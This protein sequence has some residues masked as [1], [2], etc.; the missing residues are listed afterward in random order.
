MFYDDR[1]RYGA[2]VSARLAALALS[3][4]AFAF[5]LAPAA[6]AQ[7]AQPPPPEEETV[8]EGDTIVV[9]GSILRGNANSINPIGILSADDM[10]A[11]GQT[12]IA[13]ALQTLSGNAG[14][15]LPNSFTA[16]GA[17]AG[18]ASTVSLRGLLSS[19]TLTLVD[20]MRLSY[21]PLSDDGTRNFVDLNTIPQDV[22]ARVETLKDGASS[23]YGAD[24]IAGVIN[25]ITRREYQ[26]ASIDSSIAFRG[27]GDG[28]EQFNLSG[29][30]GHGDLGTDGYNFYISAEY[31]RQDIYWARDADFF[32]TTTSDLTSICGLTVNALDPADTE[33]CIA[34]GVFWGLEHDGTF[35]APAARGFGSANAMIRAWDGTQYVGDFSL[36][37]TSCNEHTTPGVIPGG[38]GVGFAADTNVCSLDPQ[39][40]F[41]VV[42]PEDTRASLSARLTFNLAGSHEAYLMGTYYQNDVFTPGASPNIRNRTPPPSNPIF[43]PQWRTDNAATGTRANL[44][45][46]VCPQGSFNYVC[47]GSEVGAALNPNN[48]LAGVGQEVGIWYSF[49][50]I[51]ASVRQF[52]QTFR[53]AGGFNGDFTMGGHEY[54]YDIGATGMQ[55]NLEVTAEG[56]LFFPNLMAAIRQGTYNFV[57][58]SQ[59]TDEIRDFVSPTSVQRSN[60]KLVQLQASVSTELFE[61]PGGMAEGGLLASARYES[62]DNPSANSDR[63][64]T[65]NRYF[66]TINPFGA[67]GSRDTQAVGFEL[68]LPV[69]EQLNVNVSGRYDTYSTGASDFSPKIGFRF[70]PLEFL[71][72]RGTYSEGFR[73]PS[74]GETAA[75]PTTGFIAAQPDVDW[76]NANHGG[77]PA[78]CG[79]Y[80]LGLSQIAT[81][82]LQPEESVNM[83]L[84]VVVR[85]FGNWAFSADY[86]SIE[87]ENV[88]GAVDASAAIAAYYAGDPIPPGIT[89]IEDTPNP[90]NPAGPLRIA[91]VQ[92]PFANLGEQQVTGWDFQVSGSFDLGGVEW[93]T[94]GEATYLESLTQ[95]FEGVPEQEYA[96]TIGPYIITAASGTPQWRLNWQNTFTFG[97]ASLSLT[98]YWTEGYLSV[99]E[100][101]GGDADDDTCASGV[102]TGAP[103][104]YLDGETIIVCEVDDSFYLDAHG[105]YDLNDTVQIYLNVQN[106]LGE[107]P[108]YDPTTYGAVGYNPSW[109][110]P[111][112]LGRFFTIGARAR[113]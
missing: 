60:S 36:L 76:C 67:S 51:D 23:T 24:A 19:N 42:S 53:A 28:A 4:S 78:Y 37:D 71:A 109:G 18:G 38:A 46:F 68:D 16:N 8:E 50:D 63:G 9:T 65:L 75:D 111:G 66:Q 113:F 92:T 70:E 29:I 72:F 7:D 90:N 2:P 83:N 77:D 20:G 64:G 11:R 13:D 39:R 12:T 106:V 25:M 82:D 101:I 98:A 81:P 86:F 59:N 14:G 27:A 108:A 105:A 88:I 73:I 112:I 79:I 61:L 55:Q 104:T 85:P 35:T 99:A 5:A 91:Y 17:F 103:A 15:S 107:D 54:H 31:Q 52:V 21:F 57:D 10:A 97:P 34:T 87:K 102:G 100:D 62:L 30:W 32:P 58:P 26:G 47:D 3:V 56:S 80:G 96:G 94:V 44:P 48:P 110:T 49:G 95:A 40:E 6:Y 89:I 74:F 93:S 41:G 45:V 69:F 1:T 84:G 43:G 33:T 22:I